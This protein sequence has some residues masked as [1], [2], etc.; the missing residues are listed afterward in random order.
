MLIIIPTL[1]FLGT[2]YAGYVLANEIKQ[3]KGVL[4]PVLAMHRYSALAGIAIL[5][6][7]I[8]FS[9][10][11]P[12]TIAAFVTLL[13]AGL[14]GFFLFRLIYKNQPPPMLIVYGHAGIAITGILILVAAFFI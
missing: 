2:A 8:S 1:V 4:A 11:T 6:V 7:I 14:G 10:I 9:E 13:T 5:A 3:K 12:L